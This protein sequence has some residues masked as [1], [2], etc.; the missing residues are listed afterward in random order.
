MRRMTWISLLLG[1][2]LLSGCATSEK[3]KPHVLSGEAPVEDVIAKADESYQAGDFRAAAILY[4]IAIDTESSADAWFRLGMANNYLGERDKAVYSFMQALN[5]DP[6]HPG[7]LEK[8][9]LFYTSRGDVPRAREYLV[10]LLEVD[11]NNWRAH[12]SMGVLADLEKEFDQAR[13]HYLAALKIRPD[14]AMLWNNLGYSVYLMGDLERAIKYITRALELDPHHEASRQNLALVYVRQD[15]FEAALA[16]LLESE[17]VPT[18]YTNIGYLAY[19]VGNYEKAEEYL[20]EAIRQSPVYN[21]P[22]HTYLAATRQASKR[23]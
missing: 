19:M 18:A 8:M 21:K 9:A 12:N 13:D 22:A 10:K 17:D 2:L 15:E 11:E 7:A 16:T 5:Q 3:D 23:G 1:M 6:N 20:E 4:Q 14:L